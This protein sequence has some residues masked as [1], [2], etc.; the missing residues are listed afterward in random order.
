M[1]QLSRTEYMNIFVN[2]MDMNY[3]G[4]QSKPNQIFSPFN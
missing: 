4:S 3:K 1:L 2:Y